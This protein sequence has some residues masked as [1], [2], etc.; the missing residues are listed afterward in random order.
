[1]MIN[2]TNSNNAMNGRD[3]PQILKVSEEKLQKL[4]G[5]LDHNDYDAL[6][7]ARRENFAWLTTGG[8]SAVV[9]S[10][11]NGIGCFLIKK[12]RQYLISHVMDGKRLIEEQLP[13]QNFELIE[14]RWYE[15]EPIQHA[16][17]LA[18]PKAAADICIP[19]IKNVFLEILDLHYPM[20]ELEME[21]L[22]WLGQTMHS[23]FKEM[24]KRIKPGMSEIEIAAEFQFLQAKQGIFSDVLIAGSDGRVINFRHPM[25]TDKKIEQF[26]MLHSA[27]R[28]WGLHAPITRLFSIGEPSPNFLKPFQTVAEI[29]ARILDILKPGVLYSEVLRLIKG[30][31]AQAGFPNEW[32]NHFQG[33]P[34]GYVIVDGDRCLTEKV[35]RENTPF[36]WF[37]T[38]PGSKV[39]ELVLLDDKQA[40]IASNGDGW[41]QYSVAVNGVDYKTPGIMIV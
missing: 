3:D 23:I 7:L 31:Y 22:A 24:S 35:I 36:E 19:G 34:T 8:D 41:P 14:I 27:S 21:R 20:S 13:S 25:P 32:R 5:W 26:V 17:K 30:W 12:D 38:V 1:M 39:A 15:G 6:I 29:Q 9:N 37:I 40:K 33:G 28:K 16:L 10:T 11:H 18:G 2:L 4:R